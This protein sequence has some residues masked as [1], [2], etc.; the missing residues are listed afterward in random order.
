MK[1]MIFHKSLKLI[2]YEV[3]VRT[4]KYCLDCTVELTISLRMS[5]WALR[6][7]CT[8][9][10][11]SLKLYP[12]CLNRFR[13]DSVYKDIVVDLRTS[14]WPVHFCSLQSICDTFYMNLYAFIIKPEIRKL[15]QL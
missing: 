7:I 8:F 12:M 9:F 14:N 1:I 10:C 5:D 6:V 2:C 15:K 11:A 13:N 4:V 3:N